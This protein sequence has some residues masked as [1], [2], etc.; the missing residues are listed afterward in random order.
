MGVAAPRRFIDPILDTML[1]P[2]ASTAPRGDVRDG[3]VGAVSWTLNSLMPVPFHTP[4][5]P[6]ATCISLAKMKLHIS[7]SYHPRAGGD[8]SND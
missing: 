4:A 3:P 6:F 7:D 1:L 5:M 8:H 2:T